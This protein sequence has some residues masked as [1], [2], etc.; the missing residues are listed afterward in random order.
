MCDSLYVKANGEMPCWDD[1]G[2]DL[3]LRQLEPGAMIAGREQNLFEFDRLV[4]IRRAF[5]SGHAPYPEYCNRC[6][7]YGHGR[8]ERLRPKVMRV[9]HVE[10]SYLCH[11]NCWYCVPSK[12]RRRSK[13]PP[14]NMEPA[15]YEALLRRL[16][17]EGVERIGLIHFEGRGDPMTNRKLGELVRLSRRHYP[18]SLTKVTTHGNFPYRSWIVDSGLDILR[19]SIDGA[20]QESYETYRV[21]G[22]LD[23]A[24]ELLRRTRDERARK[25]ACLRTEWK[26]I[27]FEWNDSDEEISVAARIADEL[28]VTLSFCLTD[29]P[30]RSRR[31]SN[32]AELRSALT[33]VAPRSTCQLP[34]QLKEDPAGVEIDELVGEHA[35][36]LLIDA[37]R[38]Y[39]EGKAERGLE[40]L[41]QGLSHDPG[42]GQDELESLGDLPAAA[43]SEEILARACPSTLSALANIHLQIGSHNIARR[44][45]EGYLRLAPCATDRALVESTVEALNQRDV[46]EILLKSLGAY[47]AG[48]AA[49]GLELLIQGLAIDP[50]INPDELRGL[51]ENPAAVRAEE[52]LS[53][54]RFPATQS[55]LANI[56]VQMGLDR[57]ARDFFCGYLRL[58]P[59]A[60]DRTK[61]EKKMSELAEA[62][63]DQ[64]SERCHK[65]RTNWCQAAIHRIVG[66]LKLWRQLPSPRGR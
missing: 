50:G 46:E 2:E 11:L 42:F 39:E 25:S 53:T 4:A 47:Q 62:P 54:A 60:A 40:L 61:I 15:F 17:Q 32:L 9:L 22:R 1:S 29:A 65:Q 21:G 63:T 3:I 35:E 52:I 49:A 57:I 13:R 34:F 19:C 41:I 16:K 18:E 56:H 36:G 10:A 7:M 37:L 8:A 20:W 43:L 48:N 27:L 5:L 33:L 26:Y 31:F 23:M 38:A 44:F 30:G 24:F 45:F 6:A 59:D 55:A 14:Y 12:E 58:A 64:V 51:G 28:E 66:R